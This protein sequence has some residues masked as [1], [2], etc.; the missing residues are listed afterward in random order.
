LHVP[1]FED[2]QRDGLVSSN[3]RKEMALPAIVTLIGRNG[4]INF[5]GIDGAED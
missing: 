2:P 5:C 3:S 4:A 1:F